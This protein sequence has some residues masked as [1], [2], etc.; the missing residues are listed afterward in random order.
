MTTVAINVTL[1]IAYFK[2]CQEGQ[3]HGELL[4]RANFRAS[5][6][7]TL[8]SEAFRSL[9]FWPGRVNLSR[10]GRVRIAVYAI[11]KRPTS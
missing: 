10:E 4:R 6:R 3:L 7:R 9:K 11:G 8:K 5:A 1:D 2:R